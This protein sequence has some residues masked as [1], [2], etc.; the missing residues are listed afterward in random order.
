M[1][2][3]DKIKGLLLKKYTEPKQIE[4]IDTSILYVQKKIAEVKKDRQTDKW[5]KSYSFDA[6]FL[7]QSIAECI[8]NGFALD[9]VNYVISGNRMYMPTYKAFK[10]KIYMVYP[11][12]VI[13]IQI[14]REGDDFSVNKDSGAVNYEHKINNPFDNKAVIG[15]Y[16]VIKNKRGEF[17]ELLNKHDYEEMKNG[18]KNPALWVKWDS[19]F[20]RKS[21]IK[22]ACKTH[23][24][25]ITSAIEEKDNQ[26]IGLADVV[27]ADD[28][29][30]AS[31]IE[32]KKAKQNVS[33]TN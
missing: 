28:S 23:F 16:C 5:V 9:G 12:S 10:N 32:A 3:I 14:V 13:D 6:T 18:S 21:V 8:D 30:K 31:I 22:R 26:V 11:E 29:K 2:E 20:W 27:K 33:E 15:A 1:D 4:L 17:L 25:D 24:N 7:L 19:E